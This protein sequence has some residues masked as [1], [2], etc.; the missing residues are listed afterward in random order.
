M[1]THIDRAVLLV[2]LVTGLAMLTLVT[3]ARPL[4]GLLG[5]DY[6]ANGA[7]ALRLIGL[8]LPFTGVVL[9]YAAFAM[10]EKRMWR[11]VLV[12]SAGAVICLGGAVLG[13]PRFGIA[14]PALALLVGQAVTA[15]VLLPGLV[16]RYRATALGPVAGAQREIDSKGR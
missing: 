3:A 10:M 2:A 12:Q 7:D 15:T 6:A 1:R 8:S 14:A 5:P 11:V 13:L 9:L 16:R 4:L